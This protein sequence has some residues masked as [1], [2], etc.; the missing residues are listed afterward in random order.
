MA[1]PGIVEGET[2][3]I[4]NP[5]LMEKYGIAT[6]S[7]QTAAERLAEEGKTPLWIAIE[8]KLAGIIAVADTIKPT[9]IA[10]IRQMHAEG[11]RVVMLT[12]DNERTA[13]AIAREA[14]VDE[15]IAG[16][17]SGMEK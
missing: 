15:V 10:A 13:R 11:L 9:S 1:L 12:G 16:C 6:E 8:G 17:A 2:T 5:A 3:L 7:L 4:G 14:G